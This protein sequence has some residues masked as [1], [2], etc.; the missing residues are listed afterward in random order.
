MRQIDREEFLPLGPSQR[1]L[2]EPYRKTPERIRQTELRKFELP[3]RAP[4]PSVLEREKEENKKLRQKLRNIIDEDCGVTGFGLSY[5]SKEEVGEPEV[6][7]T[8]HA[9][10]SLKHYEESD[11]CLYRGPNYKPVLVTAVGEDK[12][13]L[14]THYN[15]PDRIYLGMVGD[16]ISGC[17][18]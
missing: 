4:H 10:F 16:Y 9:Y 12:A 6:K 18:K 3:E 13:W 14:E 8:H 15:W 11:G 17:M 5:A 1:T 2:W 7:L